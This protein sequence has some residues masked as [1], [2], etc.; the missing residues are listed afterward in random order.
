MVK[1]FEKKT[2]ALNMYIL[3]KFK[4]NVLSK[5]KINRILF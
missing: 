5:N 4:N 3:L 2:F 1:I